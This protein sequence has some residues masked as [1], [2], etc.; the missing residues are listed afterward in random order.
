MDA[1]NVIVVSRNV[2]SG[3]TEDYEK[4]LAKFDEDVYLENGNNILGD[5]SD[6]EQI[7]RSFEGSLKLNARSFAHD[8]EETMVREDIDAFVEP[9]ELEMEER[10]RSED[11]ALRR[12][13]SNVENGKP[14]NQKTAAEKCEKK[15]EN[16]VDSQRKQPFALRTKNTQ[17]ND[18]HIADSKAKPAPTQIKARVTKHSE[19]SSAP[20]SRSNLSEGLMEKPKREAQ[21]TVGPD[22]AE[23]STHSSSSSGTGDGK[24]KRLGS[25]P[26]YGFSFKCNE[27]AEKRR[28]YYSRLE[29]KIQAK[30]QEENTL[31]ARTK[32]NQEAEIKNLR[33][34]LKFKATPL[35]S[36][37]QEPPPP[38]AELKKIPTTRAKSP[39]FA[40]KKDFPSKDS[41]KNIRRSLPSSRQSIDAKVSHSNSVKGHSPVP[42]K[43]PTRKSL[44]KLPSER[45][46][47]SSE[48]TKVGSR[49]A[50]S[51]SEKDKSVSPLTSEKDKSISPEIVLSNNCDENASCANHEVVANTEPSRSQQLP[52]YAPEVEDQTQIISVEESVATK[53]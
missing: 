2:V 44:P 53:D 32:E 35:P 10:K 11:T 17:I 33:K 46:I 4:H 14:L 31:Q 21:K 7:N 48:R 39:K 6:T 12:D 16:T 41:E 37:Y 49:K 20:S 19:K 15:V 40:R 23:G 50:A 28:E 51:T 36:F 47:I 8:K 26:T 1:D 30:E 24:T 42:V 27:R 13:V 29:E 25:L 9:K 52:E 5:D 3:E 38:K 45:T 43:K 34:S 22:K 18:K